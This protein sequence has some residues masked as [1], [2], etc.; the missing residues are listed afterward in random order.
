MVLKILIIFIMFIYNID[1]E[2]FD[3][4]LKKET[5]KI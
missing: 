2:Q 5:M 4:R 3:Y 1:R